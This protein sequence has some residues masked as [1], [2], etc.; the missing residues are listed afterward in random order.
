MACQCVTHS[1][2]FMHVQ[3]NTHVPHMLEMITLSPGTKENISTYSKHTYTQ[4]KAYEL[5][6][7]DWDLLANMWQISKGIILCQNTALAHSVQNTPHISNFSEKLWCNFTK[8]P[9]VS[10]YLIRRLWSFFQWH[11]PI[12][13]SKRN[14]WSYVKGLCMCM[15]SILERNTQASVFVYFPVMTLPD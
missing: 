4:P 13:R 5:Q 1:A 7:I 2:F 9:S 11:T 10:T 12:C 3:H 14:L 15:V 8:L 6:T